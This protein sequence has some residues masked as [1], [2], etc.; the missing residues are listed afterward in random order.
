MIT[1]QEA[2]QIALKGRMHFE[3]LVE[4][5]ADNAIKAA[6]QRGELSC[7]FRVEGIPIPEFHAKRIEGML[8]KAGYKASHAIGRDGSI[9]MAV[10]WLKSIDDFPLLAQLEGKK[11]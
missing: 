7:S 4:K 8:T 3:S 11:K 5:T 1:A 9:T 10:C 6:A 2:G